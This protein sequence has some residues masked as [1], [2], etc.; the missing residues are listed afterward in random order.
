ME[1][2]DIFDRI[3][4]AKLFRPVRPFYQRNKEILLY[5]LFGALTTLV[6]ILSFWLFHTPL[7]LHELVANAVS[8]VLAVLF[9]FYT[10]RKWVFKGGRE[11][12]LLRQMGEFFA[13]RLLTLGAEELILWVFITRMGWRDMPVKLGASVLV[14]VLNYVV[15]KLFVFHNNRK[16]EDGNHEGNG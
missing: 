14:I 8:W 6:S 9:A 16:T 11:K 12:S 15:S 1:Q 2:R 5:L 7:G 13:G 3:M 4:D 10:N